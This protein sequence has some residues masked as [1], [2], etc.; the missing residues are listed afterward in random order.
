MCLKCPNC[1]AT[2]HEPGAKF[3]HKCGMPLISDEDNYPYKNE[4]SPN[5]EEEDKLSD[6]EDKLAEKIGG[7]IYLVVAVLIF[8]FYAY[9][10]FGLILGFFY[11][12]WWTLTVPIHWLFF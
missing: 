2:D 11:S 8:F 4:E 1:N 5:H 7:A 9:K 6:D 3:C 12:L 10:K